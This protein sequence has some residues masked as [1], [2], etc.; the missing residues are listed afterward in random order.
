MSSK[1][2][3]P[4][5]KKVENKQISNIQFKSTVL[6]KNPNKTKM[7]RAD[8]NQLNQQRNDDIKNGFFSVGSSPTAQKNLVDR[9]NFVLKTNGKKT[10]TINGVKGKPSP[11][12][13]KYFLKFFK[14]TDDEGNPIQ[15]DHQANKKEIKRIAKF[16]HDKTDYVETGDKDYPAVGIIQKKKGI[17]VIDY[18]EKNKDHFNAHPGDLAKLYLLLTEALEKFHNARAASGKKYVHADIKLDNI[19]IDETNGVLSINII[20]FGMVKQEGKIRQV[21]CGT[22]LFMAPEIFFA[23]EKHE[24]FQKGDISEKDTV[25]YLAIHDHYSLATSM[26]HSCYC[27]DIKNDFLEEKN[28]KLFE[29]KITDHAGGPGYMADFASDPKKLELRAISQLICENP[30][31]LDTNKQVS[32]IKKQL[33]NIINQQGLSPRFQ[34][35]QLAPEKVETKKE[36]PVINNNAVKDVQAVKVQQAPKTENLDKK[37]GK[38]LGR[39]IATLRKNSKEHNDPQVKITAKN[40]EKAAIAEVKESNTIEGKEKV[41][42]A[43]SQVN[44]VLK[45]GHDYSVQNKGQPASNIKN[46]QDVKLKKSVED[47]EYTAKSSGFKKELCAALLA[48]V[49]AVTFAVGFVIANPIVMGV[50]IAEFVAGGGALA[51]MGLFRSCS[52]NKNDDK[53]DLQIAP[54]RI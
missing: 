34:V 23:Q 9:K 51:T 35:L 48:V 12:E 39:E 50:G 44:D 30:S 31:S 19:L 8:K 37:V 16:N 49:G 42:G 45:N 32:A 46:P 54:N 22:P 38:N 5:N 40:L 14:S 41:I 10:K 53:H 1:S 52:S 18:L 4:K 24:S 25:K 47:T 36:K 29:D 21:V 33:N 20:D 26:L 7:F 27:L 2:N 28:K 43:I 13:E 6:S 17:E 15:I 3:E 11:S